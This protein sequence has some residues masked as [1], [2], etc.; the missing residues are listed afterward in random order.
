MH[1]VLISKLS[2]YVG[3]QSPAHTKTLEV[4]LSAERLVF[5]HS[6]HLYIY[7]YIYARH[8]SNIDFRFEL[9]RARALTRIT[10]N[11]FVSHHYTFSGFNRRTDPKQSA[12]AHSSIGAGADAPQ[13]C[14]RACMINHACRGAHTHTYSTVCVSVFGN[15]NDATRDETIIAVSDTHTYV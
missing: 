5:G 11:Q 2:D 4:N 1:Y 15:I 10:H 8:Y 13:T 7:I 14:A 6:D 12:H 3:R 9:W